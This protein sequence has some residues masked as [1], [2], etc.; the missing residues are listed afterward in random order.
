MRC[1]WRFIVYLFDLTKDANRVAAALERDSTQLRL[2]PLTIGIQEDSAIVRSFP[3]AEKIARED[4]MATPP[5][6]RR[7]RRG[8]VT[9]ANVAENP[10]CSRVNPANDS[11]LIDRVRR[12]TD[13]LK[14]VLHICVECL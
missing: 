14:R 13:A 4:L 8:H 7:K 11:E 1:E 5:L 6:L 9:P 2:D 10:P 3:R 12:D